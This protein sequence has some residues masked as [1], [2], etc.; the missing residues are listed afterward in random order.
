M[1]INTIMLAALTACAAFTGGS[2]PGAPD[3]VRTFGGLNASFSRVNTTHHD[4]T[5]I[6][7]IPFKEPIQEFNDAARQIFS[8]TMC[9]RLNLT[10]GSVS[11]VVARQ[12]AHGGA[13]CAQP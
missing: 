8:D 2:R 6:L 5:V 13:C 3:S 1:Y 12:G 11:L 4:E 10:R 7:V 9:I